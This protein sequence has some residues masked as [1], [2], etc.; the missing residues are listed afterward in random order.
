MYKIWIWRK[1]IPLSLNNIILPLNSK[2]FI[3]RHRRF[4]CARTVGQTVNIYL[5]KWKVKSFAL[6]SCHQ[7]APVVRRSTKSK[8]FVTAKVELLG[9]NDNN[10]DGTLTSDVELFFKGIDY[11]SHYYK[12]LRQLREWAIDLKGGPKRFRDNCQL[13]HGAILPSLSILYDFNF[14]L[15]ATTLTSL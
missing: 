8:H 2:D 6:R 14:L 15:I 9:N 1:I 13:C 3:E 4:I 5:L 12:S 7:E 10:D 11:C